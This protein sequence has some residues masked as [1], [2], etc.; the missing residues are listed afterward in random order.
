[1]SEALFKQAILGLLDNLESVNDEMVAG[2]GL[3]REKFASLAE[4]IDTV[5]EAKGYALLHQLEELETNN[6]FLRDL[7]AKNPDDQP[8]KPEPT[9]ISNEYDSTD[10]TLYMADVDQG[11]PVSKETICQIVWDRYSEGLPRPDPISC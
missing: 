4:V 3:A 9:G 1:M 2:L 11:A 8:W 7:F 10:Y 5:L 6:K